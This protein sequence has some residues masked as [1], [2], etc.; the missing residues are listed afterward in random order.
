MEHGER[1]TRPTGSMWFLGIGY[2]S[3]GALDLAFLR[4]ISG[5]IWLLLGVAW[6]VDEIARRKDKKRP[7][8]VTSALLA[9]VAA[10]CLLGHF[11]FHWRW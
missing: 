2:A 10:W 1:R 11:L 5:G 6:I 7:R 8:A 3:I 9:V 4:T